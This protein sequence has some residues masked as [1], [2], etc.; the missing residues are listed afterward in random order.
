MSNVAV[1]DG[2]DLYDFNSALSNVT[3]QRTYWDTIKHVDAKGRRSPL[4]PPTAAQ[5]FKHAEKFGPECVNETAA[6]YGVKLERLAVEKPKRQRRS[7]PTVKAQVL[8]LHGRGALP[9]AIADTLN[10]SD[11]R[12]KELLR[13]AA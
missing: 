11:R 5:L 2:S 8:E 4:A 3:M 7:G 1:Y 9:A 13:D 6:Q 10:L 12:V